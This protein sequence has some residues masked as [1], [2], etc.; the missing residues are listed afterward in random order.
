M[1]ADNLVCG[2][3]AGVDDGKMMHYGRQGARLGIVV[4][5]AGGERARRSIVTSRSYP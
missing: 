2:G 4:I 3:N 1:A 5:S